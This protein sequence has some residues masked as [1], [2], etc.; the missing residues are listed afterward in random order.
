MIHY[1][2]D[3]EAGPWLIF[4]H[5]LTC[6]GRDWRHQVS[7][8][9]GGHRCLSVDLRGHGRSA[10][11][12]GP[13]DMETLAGDVAALMHGLAI[14]DA[15]L[16]GHSMGTRV[17][18]ALALQVPERV[19]ALVFVDGSQQGRGDPL[20][21]RQDALA[22]LG[23]GPQ[24]QTFTKR[25][26]EAMFTQR[27][28]DADRR[29]ITDRARAMP[30]PVFRELFGNMSAWD[31][32]RMEFALSQIRQPVTVLQSTRVT[33]ARER[34]SLRADERTPYLDMLRARVTNVSIEVIPEV[35]HFTQLE[36]AAPVSRIIAAVAADPPGG[37]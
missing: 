11:I 32:G 37:F 33:P 17:I 15:V 6:D 24:Q 2:I 9:A 14:G 10:H 36:A 23:E 28:E 22:V 29:A 3:G 13:Y 27:C 26:F 18:T 16:I 4:V 7:A 25:M 34:F 8:L 31:A 20:Q 12:D 1:D 5:G 30:A 19:R 35:G 21:S